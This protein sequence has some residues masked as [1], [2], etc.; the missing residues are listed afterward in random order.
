MVIARWVKRKEE[1]INKLTAPTAEDA[2][3]EG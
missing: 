1:V 2:Q 3:S